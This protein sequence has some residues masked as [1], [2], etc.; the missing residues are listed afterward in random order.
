MNLSFL[1]FNEDNISTRITLGVLNHQLLK[2][3]CKE[4]FYK[5]KNF[6]PLAKEFNSV[7]EYSD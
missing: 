3:P 6:R 1:Q 7:P 2:R 5:F 4:H